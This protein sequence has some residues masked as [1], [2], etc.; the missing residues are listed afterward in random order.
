[1]SRRFLFLIASTRADGN[2]EALARAAAAG[3]DAEQRWIRLAEHELEPFRDVRHSDGSFGP[4]EGVAATLAE[5]TLW[6]TDLVIVTPVYWYSLPAAAKLYFDHWTGW[7]RVP[8]LDFRARMVG[9]ALWA[10]VVDASEPDER[11]FDPLIGM[12]ARTAEYMDMAWKGALHGHANRPGEL[13]AE[14][15]AAAARYFAD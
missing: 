14:Q 15:L 13:P 3:L 9:R 11:A 10:V 2:S 4:P 1:M 12:L 5:A 6:A 7:L 8:A